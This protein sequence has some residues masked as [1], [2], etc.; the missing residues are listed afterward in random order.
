MPIVRQRRRC[1]CQKL[2]HARWLA[3]RRGALTIGRRLDRWGW[4]GIR[5]DHHRRGPQRPDLRLLS[6][7]EGP[8]GRGPRGVGQRSAAPRLP[9]NSC[10]ASATRA[11]SYTVSLLNPK[12]IR[13]IELERHGLKVVL[14]KTRQFPARRRRLS[15]RRPQRP[16]AQGDRPPSTRPTATAYDRYIAELETVVPLLK[17]WMLRAPPEVGARA[18]RA[19]RSCSASAATWSGCRPTKSASSTI[20]RRG[21][22]ATSST[23]ISKG[24]LAKALFGFDGVV[25]NFASPY[26]PGTRL[27]PAPPFVRRGGR[28]SGRLGPCHRRHGLDHPGDGPRLPRGGRRHPPQHAGRGDHRRQGPRRGRGRRAARPGARKTV[29]AG[30][31]PKLLFDRLV[32]QGRGRRRR[33]S[34]RMHALEVRKRDLPDERR[35]VRTAE[36]HRRF[37]RRAII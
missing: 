2:A 26:T 12:V 17:K 22:P 5:R 23:A 15:A 31:N 8:Q 27:R 25:G 32:P 29:V 4:N 3:A 36:V 34:S 24:D 18:Q 13:D 1:S 6:G 33:R 35:S 16:D 10:P 37:P 11:A 21:A 7:E 14:R 19:C 9:T 30:V 28:R 20:S